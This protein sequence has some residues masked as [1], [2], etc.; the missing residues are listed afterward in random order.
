MLIFFSILPKLLNV[1]SGVASYELVFIWR[2]Y[3]VFSKFTKFP[4]AIVS[5]G[6][7]KAFF[8]ISQDHMINDSVGEVSSPLITKVIVRATELNNKNMYV[9]QIGPNLCYKLG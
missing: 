3:R 6:R 4:V 9:L 1:L 8:C 5:G 2:H 7:D